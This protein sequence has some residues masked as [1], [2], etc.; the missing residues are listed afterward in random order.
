MTTASVYLR[1]R[2]ESFHALAGAYETQAAN[3][4]NSPD[5]RDA[6]NECVLRILDCEHALLAAADRIEERSGVRLALSVGR[7]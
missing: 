3:I 5:E 2:A 1:V 6:Y 4:A 7:E